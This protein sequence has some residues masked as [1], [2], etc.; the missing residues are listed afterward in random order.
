MKYTTHFI[1]TLAQKLQGEG[2]RRRR[3]IRDSAEPLHQSKRA[4]FATLRDEYETA[5]TLLQEAKNTLLAIQKREG[6]GGNL[7][8]EGAYR[9]ALEEFVE[10]HFFLALVLGKPLEPITKITIPTEVYMAGLLDVP[11]EVYRKVLRLGGTADPVTITALTDALDQIM[12]TIQTAELTSYLRNKQ[13]QAKHAAH[14]L[15]EAVFH[16][17]LRC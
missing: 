16:L 4:I 13:D 8:E 2:E 11:G 7:H 15:E 1:S 9:A 17:R 5:K 12:D 6:K 3:I 14:K 10:A